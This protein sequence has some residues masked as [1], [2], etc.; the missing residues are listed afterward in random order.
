M[1]VV[2]AGAYGKLGSDILRTL[3]KQGHQVVAADIIDRPVA[4]LDKAGYVYRRLDV[5]D[6]PS[7]QGLCDGADAVITTVGLTTVNAKLTNYDIDHQGNL[8]L[9]GEALRAHVGK[10]VYISVLHADAAPQDVPMVYAKKMMEDKIVASGIPYVIHRPSGYFYDI[11]KVFKPMIAKGK[12]TL[13]GTRPVYAN[14]VDTPDFAAFIVA[15]LGDVNKVYDVGGRETWSYRQIAEMCFAAAGRQPKIATAPTWLFDV[16]A[17]LPANRANGKR[18]I[19]RFSKWT[20]SHDMVASTH[21]GEHSFKQYISDS[22][23]K[24]E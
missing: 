20:L 11:V 18:P 8:N 22:F 17:A 1:K 24:G 19:I 12:V 14:V 21:V 3:V 9:L 2:L 10:F 6:A 4:G 5:T 16:L 13:L 23:T 7:L 15:H